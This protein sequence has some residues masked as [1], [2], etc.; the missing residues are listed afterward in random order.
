MFILG[1][2][3]IFGLSSLFGLFG[4]AEIA[5]TFHPVRSRYGTGAINLLGLFGS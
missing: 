2:A 5:F 1:N 4:P 3:G